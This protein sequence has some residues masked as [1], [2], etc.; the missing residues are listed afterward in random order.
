[1]SD[2]PHNPT[3][4]PEELLWYSRAMLC[5][6]LINQQTFCGEDP[7]GHVC[8]QPVTNM[9]T[10]GE[11]GDYPMCQRCALAVGSG[12]WPMGLHS[13]DRRLAD[14]RIMVWIRESQP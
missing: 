3:R 1:M 13:I 7:I 12:V 6:N 8:G 2:A 14:G 10:L 9:L 11:Y 4:R 5:G